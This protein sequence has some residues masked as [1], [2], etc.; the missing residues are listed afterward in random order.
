MQNAAPAMHLSLMDL[1]LFISVAELGNLT[2]AAQ[3]CHLSTA[4]ASVRIRALE[5]QASC[6]LLDRLPRGVRL[7]SAGETFAQHARTMLRESQILSQQL[8]Q[9]AGGMQGH[10]NILANTTACTEIMPTVLAQF[11]P[12]HGRIS[13]R[14]QEGSNTEIAHAVRE[15]R[16][17]MGVLA[18]EVDFTGLKKWRFASDR[19]VAVVSQRHPWVERE[20]VGFAELMEQPLIALNQGSSMRDFVGEKVTSMGLPPIQPRV[21]V[22]SFDAMCLLVAAGIGV[23]L[24]GESVVL[25]YRSRHA[26]ALLP[27]HDVWG[28]RQRYVVVRDGV[29]APPYLTRLAEAILQEW[30]QD[31]ND[32]V[33]AVGKITAC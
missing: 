17:D 30:G 29:A 7:T 2:L 21:E 24:A 6:R 32:D 4:A 11:L 14:M 23:A 26:I 28:F 10:I 3:R 25:R 18:G 20:S 33:A 9:Y 12:Q 22:G 1:R 8:R 5:E 16:A 19:V 15:G 27:L 31:L 13:V